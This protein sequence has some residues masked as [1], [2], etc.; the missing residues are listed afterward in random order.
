MHDRCRRHANER[1]ERIVRGPERH[2]LL[3]DLTPQ[4]RRAAQLQTLLSLDRQWSGRRQ[5]LN[6]RAPLDREPLSLTTSL[7]AGDLGNQ[8]NME[9]RTR[10]PWSRTAALRGTVYSGTLGAEFM[11]SMVRGANFSIAPVAGP[12]AASLS[13]SEATVPKFETAPLP[14]AA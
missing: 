12:T 10:T 5:Q 3:P 8:E 4:P 7:A 1:G 11:G 6:L 9:C 13:A 14:L 2:S